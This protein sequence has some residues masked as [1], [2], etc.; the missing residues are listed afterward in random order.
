MKSL[1]GLEFRWAVSWQSL[2]LMGEKICLHLSLLTPVRISMLEMHTVSIRL[3]YT[4][5]IYRNLMMCLISKKYLNTTLYRMCSTWL[6]NNYGSLFVSMTWVTT[7]QTWLTEGCN[8]NVEI[9]LH[10]ITSLFVSYRMPLH[11]RLRFNSFFL[12]HGAGFGSAG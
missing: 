3:L 1:A 11:L 10:P 9:T 6:V 12:L 8:V 2:E 5:R 4:L 7:L